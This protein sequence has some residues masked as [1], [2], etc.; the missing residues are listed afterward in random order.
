MKREQKLFLGKFVAA[1]VVFY[2]ILASRPVDEKVVLPFTSFLVLVSTGLLKLAGEPVMSSGTMISS[3]AFSVDV[4][5]GCNGVEAMLLLVSAM[6]AFPAAARPRLAGIFAGVAIIQA[7]NLFRIASLFWL[8]V[9]HRAVFEVFHAAVWQTLL[10]LLSVAI[11]LLWSAR[12]ARPRPA[13]AR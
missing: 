6:L 1:L 4:K 8:G 5:N 12:L 10:I 9:H 7:V 11:F 13:D 3:A 2:A